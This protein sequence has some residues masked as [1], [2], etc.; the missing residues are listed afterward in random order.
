MDKVSKNE[1]RER[2]EYMMGYLL[3]K[4]YD[5]DVKIYL[6]K[7]EITN[8]NINQSSDIREK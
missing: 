5:A 4:K 6:K 1:I 7:D 3:S 2:I 8:V